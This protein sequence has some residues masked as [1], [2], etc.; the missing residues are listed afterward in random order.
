MQNWMDEELEQLKSKGLFRSLRKLDAS[1]IDF[2]SNDYLGLKKHPEM[3][4][5]AI[6][7]ASIYGS[8]SGSSRLISGNSVLYE[9][10]ENDLR[11]F[12]KVPSALVSSSGYALNVSLIPAL[13]STGDAVI[14]DRLSHASLIDGAR[15]SGARLFVYKHCD[16]NSLEQVLKRAAQFRRRLIVTDSVFSM[17]GDIA[18]LNEIAELANKYGA[19]TLVDEAHATGVIGA[20]TEKIDYCVGT[21]SKALGSLGG[22]VVSRHKSAESYFLNTVRGVIFSTALP[23]S[24]IAASIKGLELSCN[25]KSEREHLRTMAIAIRK[26][27]GLEVVKD[28]ARLSAIIPVVIGDEKKCLYIS[29]RLLEKGLFVPPVRFP[30]VAKGAARLRISLSAKQSDLDIETLLFD[31]KSHI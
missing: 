9:K 13:V 23:P 29:S 1:V 15:L 17:D 26:S 21:F 27:L 6:E 22:F 4:K 8:G 16:M 14:L 2:S 30:T 7:G 12:K 19:E 18:P 31:L 25:A 28:D 3:I 11:V 24:V 20:V 5:A 10:L